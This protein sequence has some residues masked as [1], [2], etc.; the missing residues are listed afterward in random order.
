MRKCKHGYCI[1]EAIYVVVSP[2]G[3][4]EDRLMKGLVYC[5]AHARSN[6]QSETLYNDEVHLVK[7][8][9]TQNKVRV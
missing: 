2:K 6:F 5:L 8:I 9:A 1:K 4:F 3:S 7:L